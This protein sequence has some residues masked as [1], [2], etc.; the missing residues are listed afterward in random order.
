MA[1]FLSKINFYQWKSYFYPPKLYSHRRIAIFTQDILAFLP[2][3]CH[4]YSTKIHFHQ[5]RSGEV[6]RGEGGK[7]DC[8]YTIKTEVRPSGF[9]RRRW[10]II[11]REFSLQTAANPSSFHL[12]RDAANLSSPGT[13]YPQHHVGD[14]LSLSTDHNSFL[15]TYK[16]SNNR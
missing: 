5:Q 3:E 11:F 15:H 4:F 12:P 13:P 7:G 6:G 1:L 2:Y 8:L 9:I 16:K 14:T 10:L